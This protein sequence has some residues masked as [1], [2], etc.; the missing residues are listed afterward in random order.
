M[1]SRDKIAPYVPIMYESKINLNVTA[2]GD[3]GVLSF[4]FIPVHLPFRANVHKS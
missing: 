4:G 3:R 1:V 2:F